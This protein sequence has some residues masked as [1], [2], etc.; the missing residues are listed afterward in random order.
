MPT[1]FVPNKAGQDALLKKVEERAVANML[2]VVDFAVDKARAR[3]P[4]RTGLLADEITGDVKIKDGR[5]IGRVGVKKRKKGG[6]FYWRFWEF[7]TVKLAAHPFLRPALWENLNE[8]RRILTGR[9]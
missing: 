3:A 4:R 8:I 6:A 9:S 7:G 5:V 1:R 2:D